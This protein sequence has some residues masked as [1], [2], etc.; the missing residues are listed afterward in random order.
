MATPA[1]S[2]ERRSKVS[3]FITLVVATVLIFLAV[4]TLI[5]DRIQAA[6][7]VNQITAVTELSVDSVVNILVDQSG[8]QGWL[9]LS[10]Q[11]L[12]AFKNDQGEITLIAEGEMLPL[13]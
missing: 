12:T 6:E 11:N 2:K 1:A 10:V 7:P 5:K 4:K 13:P 8:E 3:V 9:W